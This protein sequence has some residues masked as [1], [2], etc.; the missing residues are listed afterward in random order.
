MPDRL[1]D[2]LDA[3]ARRIGLDHLGVCSPEPFDRFL[4]ELD[5][6][7]DRYAPRFEARFATWRRMADPGAALDGARAV[8]VMGFRYLPEETPPGPEDGVMGRI[9]SYGHLGILRRARRVADFLR[10]RGYRAVLGVHRKDAAVRAGLGVVGKNTLVLN[11]ASGGWC[12]YQAIATDAPLEPDPPPSESFDPCASCDACMKA[13][14]TGALHE[15]YRVDPRRCMTA[16]L[17]S[18]E[19]A[20]DDRRLLGRRILGCDACLEACPYNRQARPKK[21]MTSIFPGNI[22]TSIPLRLLLGMDDCR[23]HRRILIPILRKMAGPGAVSLALRAPLVGAWFGRR[24]L[25]GLGGRETVPETFIH[26]STSLALYQRNAII[27]AANLKA[28]G[29]RDAIEACAAE[30]RLSETAAWAIEEIG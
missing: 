8:V 28:R 3:F 15:P 4:S 12:A 25:R 30:P 27:A 26:A 9:V 2:E 24:I 17:T 11:R 22:G 18:S 5:A 20:P 13:C 29:L 19:V 6:R 7:Q 21:G 16:M 14:P 1:R 10:R 23:F